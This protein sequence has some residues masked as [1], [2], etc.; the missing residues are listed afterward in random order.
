MASFGL[1]KQCLGHWEAGRLLW[2]LTFEQ[3]IERVEAGV[4]LDL[5]ASDINSRYSVEV[6]CLRI[7]RTEPSSNMAGAYDPGDHHVHARRLR[8]VDRRI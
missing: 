6:P 4:D 8:S 1:L 3:H 5:E 2:Y 7:D